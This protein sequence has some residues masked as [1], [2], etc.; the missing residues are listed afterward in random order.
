M[1]GPKQANCFAC[2]ED[3]KTLSISHERSEVRYERCTVH[4][5]K[6]IPRGPARAK[7]K[8]NAFALCFF[9]WNLTFV[10]F[11]SS[12]SHSVV[13][14][15]TKKE[16][17]SRGHEHLVDY[18]RSE[19]IYLVIRDRQRETETCRFTTVESWSQKFLQEIICDR[20]VANMHYLRA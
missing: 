13:F 12:G 17:V 7:K 16:T 14:F 6:E 2:G 10:R 11:G 20:K 15:L 19:I 3:S 8:H 5:M 9:L 1:Y 4:V 18:E